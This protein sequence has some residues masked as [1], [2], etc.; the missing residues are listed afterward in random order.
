MTA[1][2]LT[3]WM[4]LVHSLAFAI[5]LLVAG[6]IL[7]WLRTEEPSIKNPIAKAAADQ[8]IESLQALKGETS[9]PL[10]NKALDAAFHNHVV[11][12]GEPHEDDP[13]APK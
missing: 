11:A 8:V 1:D 12:V 13:R 9:S 7:R 2:W 3:P 4:P 6:I 5:V 10:L